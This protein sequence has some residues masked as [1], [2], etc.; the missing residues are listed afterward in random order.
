MADISSIVRNNPTA[1]SNARDMSK[2]L[3]SFFYKEKTR[4]A[5]ISLPKT[6]QPFQLGGMGGLPLIFD[7][8]NNKVFIDQT[9]KHSVTIGQTG[10][11]R[12]V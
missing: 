5:L 8:E 3:C 6:P 9:D 11:K 4:Q 2:Y 1:F 10:S 12:A 7:E